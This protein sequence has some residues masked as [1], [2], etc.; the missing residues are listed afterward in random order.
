MDIRARYTPTPRPKTPPRPN[1]GPIQVLVKTGDFK[2]ALE[3]LV[4]KAGIFGFLLGVFAGILAG[5][6]LAPM[7]CLD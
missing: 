1:I 4:I 7:A 2:Q 3:M 5:V 6:F